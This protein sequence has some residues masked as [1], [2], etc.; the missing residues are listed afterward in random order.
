[1]VSIKKTNTELSIYF[2]MNNS[3]Y[4]NYYFYSIAYI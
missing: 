3:S 4:R 2:I 1:M